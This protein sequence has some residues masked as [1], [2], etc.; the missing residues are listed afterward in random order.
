M[1]RVKQ[2]IDDVEILDPIVEEIN[3]EP[4]QKIIIEHDNIDN[5][6]NIQNIPNMNE[7]IDLEKLFNLT[8]DDADFN[9]NME[10]NMKNDMDIIDGIVNVTFTTEENDEERN[11]MNSIDKLKTKKNVI[12]YKKVVRNKKPNNPEVYHID[13]NYAIIDLKWFVNDDKF[14]TVYKAIYKDTYDNDL[15]FFINNNFQE[16]KLSFSELSDIQNQL[17]SNGSDLNELIDFQRNAES[18]S[19]CEFLIKVSDLCNENDIRNIYSDI[20]D[21]QSHIKSWASSEVTT[22]NDSD[23]KS[24]KDV[25]G[26]DAVGSKL[27]FRTLQYT[28]QLQ[29]FTVNDMVHLF[30][31]INDIDNDINRENIKAEDLYKIMA[32]AISLKDNEEQSLLDKAQL[33]IVNELSDYLTETYLTSFKNQEPQQQKLL[34][35]DL[36][37]TYFTLKDYGKYE[38]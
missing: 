12:D 6:S 37:K 20:P 10:K 27:L 5:I 22:D 8:P 38:V 17:N 18:I 21:L 26:K 25:Y 1:T 31:E 24:I 28:F 34:L 11:N 9:A 23:D 30:L 36:Q 2:I 3:L 13:E 19:L 16:H 29:E 4:E 35:K 7:S 33:Y 14:N 32:S 15:V